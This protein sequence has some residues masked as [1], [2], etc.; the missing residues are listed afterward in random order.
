MEKLFKNKKVLFLGAHPDD[1]ELGCGGTM[2]RA[3]EE[4]AEVYLAVFSKCEKSVPE[5]F[6]KNVLEGELSAS[7][8]A[9]KV[10]NDKVF[11]FNFPVRDFP[12][13][14][15]DILE[16][17][18][19]IGKNFNPDIVFTPST[20]D[21]HQDHKT[22]N[23]E[24]I[25]AFS[26]ATILGYE[27]PWTNKYFNYSLFVKLSEENM[28]KKIEAMKCYASQAKRRYMDEDFLRGLAKVRGVQAG[29]QYAEAFETIKLILI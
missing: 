29:T 12:K 28:S 6:P 21:N 4:G 16:E 22:I 11:F 17:L 8:K 27:L 2:N 20:G 9:L 14:R 13:N 18:V 10:E 3:I 1:I 26:S 23:N 5:G 25:R 7:A 19:K 15:Q 24:A